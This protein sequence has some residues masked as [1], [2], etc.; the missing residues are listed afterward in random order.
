[1]TTS[2]RCTRIGKI[3]AVCHRLTRRIFP[4][5]FATRGNQVN[6]PSTTYLS[7]TPHQ[8]LLHPHLVNTITW[9]TLWFKRSSS[10]VTNFYEHRQDSRLPL[11]LVATRNRS[12]SS[13][14]PHFSQRNAPRCMISCLLSPIQELGRHAELALQLGMNSRRLW[15]PPK[16]NVQLPLS[17]DSRIQ[18]P[19]S[20]VSEGSPEHSFSSSSGNSKLTH[21]CRAIAAT[22]FPALLRLRALSQSHRS[23]SSRLCLGTISG[24][25][26]DEVPAVPVRCNRSK[27]RSSLGATDTLVILTT[28]GRDRWSNCVRFQ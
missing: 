7:A 11:P 28:E 15:C 5:M 8:H 13:L 24:T 20:N 17:R 12:S 22:P 25:A 1:M 18:P 14:S 3:R 4:K 26:L 10:K 19:R 2:R 27:P 6:Q 21:P 9:Q 16:M 23:T